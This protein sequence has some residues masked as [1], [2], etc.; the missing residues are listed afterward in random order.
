MCPTEDLETA[1]DLAYRGAE[2]V[3]G[4]GQEED[5]R[6]SVRAGAP[7][8]EV[9]CGEA[10]GQRAQPRLVDKPGTGEGRPEAPSGPWR[11]EAPPTP[12]KGDRLWTSDLR[13][14][15]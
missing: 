13:T 1:N 3:T 14:A 10:P 6:V 15:R 9:Q 2:C 7:V 11:D 8:A 4:A 5:R 12:G